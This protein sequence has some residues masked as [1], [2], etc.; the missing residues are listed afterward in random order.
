MVPKIPATD[1]TDSIAQGADWDIPMT[2]M[3]AA[4]D[5][6][7][8]WKSIRIGRIL[9]CRIGSRPVGRSFDPGMACVVR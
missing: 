3:K 1:E 5:G 4:R 2:A 7:G 9:N 6:L 8:Y